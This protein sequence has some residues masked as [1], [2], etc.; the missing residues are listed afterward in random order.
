[1][2]KLTPRLPLGHNIT[3]NITVNWKDKAIFT[4]TIDAQMTIKSAVLDLNKAIF[5]ES[6]NT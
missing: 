6:E 2:W 1:M 4:F 3:T 5:I